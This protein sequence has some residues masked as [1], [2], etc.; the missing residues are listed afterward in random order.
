MMLTIGRTG[1]GRWR[2]IRDRRMRSVNAGGVKSVLT[3]S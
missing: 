1:D 2:W 3:V